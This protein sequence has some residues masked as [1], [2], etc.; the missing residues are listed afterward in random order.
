MNLN[1]PSTST[2]FPIPEDPVYDII[3]RKLKTGPDADP[4]HAGDVFNPLF[5]TI[6]NN[7]HAVKL[8]T[9]AL[10]QT[11][12]GPGG[13]ANI[14]LSNGKTIEDALADITPLFSEG[15]PTEETVGAVGQMFLNTETRD[16]FICVAVDESVYTWK[17]LGA[18]S[19]GGSS[20]AYL[21]ASYLGT[22]FL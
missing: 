1:F 9:D 7:T 20:T 8:S 6:I 2:P 15:D 17:K 19:G 12:E 11:V 22:A 13:A 10:K 16:V 4:A 14:R 3:I 21:G 18:G 5:Q